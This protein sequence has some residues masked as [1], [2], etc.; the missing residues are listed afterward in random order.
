[1]QRNS[2]AKPQ[3]ELFSQVTVVEVPEV[4]HAKC[5]WNDKQQRQITAKAEQIVAMGNHALGDHRDS[6]PAMIKT[7]K[8]S[9]QTPASRSEEFVTILREKRNTIFIEIHPMLAYSP[10]VAE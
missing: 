10:T 8:L 4:P 1:M 3:P 2:K 5:Q 9:G 6:I 7:C